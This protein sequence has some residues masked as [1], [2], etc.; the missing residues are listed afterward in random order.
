[1][2]LYNLYELSDLNIISDIDGSKEFIRDIADGLRKIMKNGIGLLAQLSKN[3][4]FV[5]S[6]V[7]ESL[8][9]KVLAGEILK[10]ISGYIKGGGGGRPHLAEGGGKNPEGW[11]DVKRDFKKIL[12][13]IVDL[14]G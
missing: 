2:L 14:Q 8:T 4:I 3:S 13:K 10:A 11:R 9:D 1:M 12:S 6:F 5:V 7:G